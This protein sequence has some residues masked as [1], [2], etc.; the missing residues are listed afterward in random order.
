MP[1]DAT[2]AKKFVR[3]EY[4]VD[5]DEDDP[6]LAPYML[7]ALGLEHLK[8]EFREMGAE[9]ASKIIL[10]S[11]G[12]L[13]KAHGSIADV[14]RQ[15]ASMQ[16]AMKVTVDAAEKAER[17]NAMLDDKTAAMSA[18]LDVRLAALDEKM[19]ALDERLNTTATLAHKMTEMADKTVQAVVALTKGLLKV[20]P[21]SFWKK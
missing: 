7:T 1:L 18:M 20:Q 2:A 12:V 6:V 17:L 5:A 4:G 8:P 14:G 10:H 16:D 9:I 11:N 3:A 21:K 13:E 15:V 19:T